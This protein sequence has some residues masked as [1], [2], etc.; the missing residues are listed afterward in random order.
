MNPSTKVCVGILLAMMAMGASSLPAKCQ[1]Q[2]PRFQENV[3]PRKK[4]KTDL[5]Y[6]ASRWYLTGATQLDMTTTFQVIHHPT[7]AHRAD[8]SVI[9]HYYG[10][11]NGWAGCLGRRS[12]GAAIGANVALNVGLYL[13]SRK[14]YHRG[15][16]WRDLAIVVNILKG[17]DN[18]MAGVHNVAYDTGVDGRI[19]MATGYS[20]PIHW[21]H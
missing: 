14:L 4:D 21:S 15:G 18:M 20:G 19:R 5:L 7:V 16:H 10:A 9:A 3:G 11:E 17:T 2:M 6:Q 12:A 1:T 13:L 8:G